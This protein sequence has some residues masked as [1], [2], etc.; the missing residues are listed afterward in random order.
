MVPI[1]TKYHK[2]Y[3]CNT[4]VFSLNQEI[5]SLVFVVV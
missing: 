2:S 4:E 1:R 3:M 5:E